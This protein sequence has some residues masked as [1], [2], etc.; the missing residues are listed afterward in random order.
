[1]LD[2]EEELLTFFH[3]VPQW[4]CYL[5][6]PAAGARWLFPDG[7]TVV[8]DDRVA[9]DDELITRVAVVLS[10]GPTH[11]SP[12]GEHCCGRI[13]YNNDTNIATYGRRLMMGR[14]QRKRQTRR[15]RGDERGK[16]LV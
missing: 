13:S 1:M 7:A 5:E 2:Q 15:G 4:L 16:L 14:G 12:D 11:N 3:H 10:R 6:G 9:V 8:S